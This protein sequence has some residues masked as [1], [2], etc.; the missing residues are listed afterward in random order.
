MRKL[1]KVLRLKL[2][3]GLSNRNIVRSCNISRSAV[4]DYLNSAEMVEVASAIALVTE[5]K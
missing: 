1:H 4:V 2:E 3:C 5:Y